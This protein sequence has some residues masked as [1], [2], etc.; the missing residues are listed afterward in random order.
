MA[1]FRG[2]IQGTRG[3][4]S[5]LG[6]EKTGLETH[7]AGWSSG[8]RVIMYVDDNEQDRCRILFTNGSRDTSGT[9]VYD[10]PCDRATVGHLCE[11]RAA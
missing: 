7:A 10:R 4:A 6:H 11:Q 3:M 2:T 5:R 8:V 1:R 9:L